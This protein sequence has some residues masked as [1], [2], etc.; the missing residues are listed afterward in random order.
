MKTM[1]FFFYYYKHKICNK[2]TRELCNY[3][4]YHFLQLFSMYKKIFIFVKSL[5]K[6]F[7]N[8]VFSLNK[9]NNKLINKILFFSSTFLSRD[10][11]H[12]KFVLFFESNTN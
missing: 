11:H 4:T 5:I 7:L 3:L 10:N 8:N 9:L 6:M 1:F 12:N 2:K